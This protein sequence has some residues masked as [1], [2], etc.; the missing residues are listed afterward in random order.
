MADA[1]LIPLSGHRIFNTN[2]ALAGNAVIYVYDSGT[3]DLHSIYTDNTLTTAASNPITCDSNG[4]CPYIYVGSD[5][6]KLVIQ[7]QGG[8]T[9][10]TEDAI[11]GALDTS[12]LETDFAKED[13]NIQAITDDYSMVA[14][15]IGTTLSVNPSATTKTITLLSAV[16]VTN[17]R[18]ITVVYTGSSGTVA[19]ATVSSQTI[20]RIGGTP[21]S[22][23]LTARG[24]YVTLRSDGANWLAVAES[25][26]VPTTTQGDILYHDG[27][28]L[29]RLA[30]GSANQILQSDGTDIAWGNLAAS[31]TVAGLLEVAVQSEMESAS[32]TT[33]AVTPGRQHYHPGHPKV[34]GSADN[35]ATV[36]S[37]Y[38][39]TSVTDTATGEITWNLA[40][41]LSDT[42]FAVHV[43][44]RNIGSR[45]G[46]IRAK[47]T[48]TTRSATSTGSTGND[49]DVTET[50][51]TLL[52]DI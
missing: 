49:A 47:T 33:L 23:N 30:L 48:T 1:A 4:L 9:L 3:S 40:I 43:T 16:T 46:S 22:M 27:T 51:M 7:T 12:N 2:G 50:F 18:G 5:D 19:I 26:D 8:T 45:T 38:G 52:G 32:S 25:S 14:N 11:K 42:N 20:T 36:N 37:S 21:T 15:D 41:T 35:A 29:T 17:G 31:D 34:W 6:Y 24:Q 44:P 13:S 10:D 39:L 28:S